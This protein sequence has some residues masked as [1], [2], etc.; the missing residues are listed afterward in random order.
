G[1]ARARSHRVAPG[2]LRT[3]RLPAAGAVWI[4]TPGSRG[5]G[6]Q[7]ATTTRCPTPASA[8][9]QRRVCTELAGASSS[10]VRRS[11][12]AM[13]FTQREQRLVRRGAEP[14]GGPVQVPPPAVGGRGQLVQA[15]Q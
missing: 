8:A 4:S 12:P 5:P 7:L 1:A 15:E 13:A 6:I 10:T 9:D 11:R 2:S 3:G 14:A